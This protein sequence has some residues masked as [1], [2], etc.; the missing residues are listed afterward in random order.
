MPRKKRIRN[1]L[2]KT[3]SETLGSKLRHEEEVHLWRRVVIQSIRDAGSP[4]LKTRAS[5]YSWIGTPEY[6]STCLA[7]RVNHIPLKKGLM[8]L[9]ETASNYPRVVVM[10][11]VSSM[12][13]E[14]ASLYLKGEA[15]SELKRPSENGAK[16]KDTQDQPT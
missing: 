7:A 10:K 4:N 14:L 16:P 5:I 11:L 1:V 15:E 13:E 12:E 9:L 6:K 3:S 8:V 2:D